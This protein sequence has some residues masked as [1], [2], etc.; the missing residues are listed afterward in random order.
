MA[1]KKQGSSAQKASQGPS[2]KRKTDSDAW[3]WWAYLLCTVVLILAMFAGRFTAGD[4]GSPKA[5]RKVVP[6]MSK[7]DNKRLVKR[8]SDMTEEAMAFS[9]K[10]QLTGERAEEFEE[11]LAEMERV[12][13]RLDEKVARKLRSVMNVMRGL[14]YQNSVNHTEKQMERAK[15]GQ[16]NSFA[17]PR[18]WDKQ[19]A[20][21]P[22]DERDDWFVSWDDPVYQ[23]AFTPMDSQATLHATKVKDLVRP[24]LVSASGGRDATASPEILM[25]G[26]GNSDMSEKMYKQDGFESIVNIDLSGVLVDKLRSHLSASC[27]RMQWLQMDMT[28][29]TFEDS[30]FDV[31]IDKG[32]LDAVEQNVEVLASAVRESCRSLRPGGFFLSIT[33]H[34]ARLRIAQLQEHVA[35]KKCQTHA[36]QKGIGTHKMYYMHV[37]QHP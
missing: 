35:W 19:Y 32:S 10:S 26:C 16:Y 34:E 23:Q 3:P 8:I 25:L 30:S 28:N 5:A 29:L 31:I 4:G 37:C 22:E 9:K 17:D 33:F 15:D 20:E 36:F 7:W 6:D 18:H 21:T 27:P 24:Y 1:G 11:E 2:G 14:L 13:E 12:I